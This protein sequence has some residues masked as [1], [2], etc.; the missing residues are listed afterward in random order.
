MCGPVTP[1]SEQS[2]FVWYKEAS[3]YVFPKF[4]G[5][6]PL[7][8]GAREGWI[9]SREKALQLRTLAIDHKLH[10]P[11]TPSWDKWQEAMRNK[12]DSSSTENLLLTVRSRITDTFVL[13]VGYNATKCHWTRK[14]NQEYFK[15]PSV[16]RATVRDTQVLSPLPLPVCLLVHVAV[17]HC[18]VVTSLARAV[19]WHQNQPWEL[20]CSPCLA[21]VCL[22]SSPR[23][24]LSFLLCC[25][26]TSFAPAICFP[27]CSESSEILDKNH[28]CLVLRKTVDLG[29]V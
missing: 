20:F 27:T 8:F 14:K 4:S 5:A 25:A 15:N 21:A 28:Q 24:T 1:W 18:W 22:S 29:I 2:I 16:G 10:C 6:A 3:I 9:V 23:V 11:L 19:E 17:A 7:H 12:R 26:G 13:R